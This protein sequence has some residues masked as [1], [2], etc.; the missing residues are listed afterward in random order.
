MWTSPEWSLKLAY[1]SSNP[2]NL[3]GFR[4][5][6][7]ITALPS[8]FPEPWVV[9]N[10]LNAAHVPAPMGNDNFTASPSGTF[11]TA[12]GLLNIAANKQEQFEALC[13]VVGRPELIDDCRFSKRQARLQNRAALKAQ[14]EEALS[15]RSAAEWWPK[16][17]EQGIPSGPVYAVPDILAHPQ[18]R[19]RGMIGRFAQVPGVDRD[20]EIVRSGFKVDGC[21]PSV[22]E[23]PPLLGQHTEALLDQFGYTSDEIVAMRNEGVI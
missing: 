15:A 23:P 10:Y 13:K 20:V 4:T 22:D 16:L 18:I 11:N 1:T 9:S 21:A 7:Q 5:N 19:D 12:D 8:G 17:A 6:S 3:G 14:L 2:G